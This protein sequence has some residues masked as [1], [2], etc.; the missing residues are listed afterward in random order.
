MGKDYLT[1]LQF[2]L[3]I[4][5]AGTYAVRTRVESR[6][7]PRSYGR[8]RKPHVHWLELLGHTEFARELK[9]PMGALTEVRMN[10]L[11][12]GTDQGLVLRSRVLPE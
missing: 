4:D 2:F 6:K 10:L 8:A 12:R 9:R 11:H 3:V 1:L 7:P 5:I